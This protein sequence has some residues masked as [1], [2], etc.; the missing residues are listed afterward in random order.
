MKV[1]FIDLPKQYESMKDDID[2]AISRVVESGSF[3]M[4]KNVERFEEEIGNYLDSKVVA[5]A[6]GSDALLICLRAAGIKEGDEVITTPFTF[7][8]TAGA[9]ARLG[10]TPVFVDIKKDTYNIDPKLIEEK[11][12]EKTRAVIPVHIFGLVAAMDEIMLLAKKHNLFVIEDACQAI[13]SEYKG[14]KA[15]T[16][17]DFG[18][19]SFFPTKNLG[20]YGDGGLISVKSDEHY[21]F[22]KAFRLHGAKK[23]Y[24]HDSVGVNSR[25][26]ALQAAI[27]SMKLKHI[28]EWN[29]KRR[30][31]ANKYDEGLAELVQIPAAPENRVHA[32]HQYPIVT[33]NRNELQK[34]LKD[35]GVASAIYYPLSLHLQECFKNLGYKKGDLP[36]SE[37]TSENI[38][39]LPIFPEMTDTQ[40]EYVINTVKKYF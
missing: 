28:D 7:F 34:F 16:I 37:K 33:D 10:A 14:K 23:K 25:L 17:G 26:D 5:C 18:T 36:I 3:I 11:I 22:L 6:S 32:Y 12:T 40:I 19:F 39:S 20:A 30:K 24:F 27:L 35:N 4:G 8:A 38:L 13:G 1:P 15:G 9:V 21:K 29:N 2:S 31:I